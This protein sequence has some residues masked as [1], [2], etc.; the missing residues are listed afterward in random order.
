MCVFAFRLL[1]VL[2][3]CII[4]LRHFGIASSVFT[5]IFAFSLLR[6]FA[7]PVFLDVFVVSLFRFYVIAFR[8]L[9]VSAFVWACFRR[10][11]SPLATSPLLLP[12]R[13]EESSASGYPEFELIP[14]RVPSRFT[15]A[16][17]PNVLFVCIYSPPLFLFLAKF[18]FMSPNA[19]ISPPPPPPSVSSFS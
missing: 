1:E 2:R 12:G 8:R 5:C 14:P 13:S 19:H 4:A 3:F 9:R 11:E 17:H 7:V 6:F 10:P 15:P 16:L 18:F